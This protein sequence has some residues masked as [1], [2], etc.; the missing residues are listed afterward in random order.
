M[1]SYLVIFCFILLG[2]LTPGRSAPV[3]NSKNEG[4]NPELHELFY[5]Y[6]EERVEPPNR[7]VPSTD[8][9]SNGV[10]EN[11]NFGY[12]EFPCG[13]G[14]FFFSAD[15]GQARPESEHDENQRDEQ[16]EDVEVQQPDEVISEFDRRR[17]RPIGLPWGRW[18]PYGGHGR[19]WPGL[20][21]YLFGPSV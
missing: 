9:P 17:R 19:R 14:A 12:R 2:N 11:G 15:S 10:E 16:G 21:D 18:K 7:K 1:P 3:T 8:S 13:G 4:L 20:W 5:P 6:D